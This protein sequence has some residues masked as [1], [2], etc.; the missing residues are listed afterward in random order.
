[1]MVVLA[2]NRPDGAELD[3]LIIWRTKGSL[4]SPVS[5][6]VLGTFGC[7]SFLL[8]IYSQN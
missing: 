4:R 2:L 6:G 1:M 5:A 3:H 8:L 7:M